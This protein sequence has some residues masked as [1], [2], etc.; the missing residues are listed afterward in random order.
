MDRDHS[1]GVIPVFIEPGEPR[2]YLLVQ[3]NAGHWGFPKGH[4]ERGESSLET[5]IRELHEETGL[6]SDRIISDHP[7]SER[8]VFRKGSG[9]VVDKSVTYFI[10]FMDTLDVA[11]QD[12]ELQDAQ[13][14][15]LEATLGRMSFEEGRKL[16]MEVH[17]FLDRD[18]SR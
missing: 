12:D 2:R 17:A 5:A 13:W 1:C 18:A 10:G 4:P 7:F 9:R 8:Y 6:T 15:D 14:G 11:Y 16:L 3:H